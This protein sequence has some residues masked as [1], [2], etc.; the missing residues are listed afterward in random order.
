MEQRALVILFTGNEVQDGTM[1][2]ICQIISQSAFSHPEDVRMYT[3]DEDNLA[4]LLA[5]N[6]MHD[7]SKKPTKVKN[8]ESAVTMLSK[9]F[10]IGNNVALTV[11]L[12]RAIPEIYGR[13]KYGKAIQHD[14]DTVENIK[15]ILKDNT[16]TFNI[17]KSL[18]GN[19]ETIKVIRK[20]FNTYFDEK[21]NV[22]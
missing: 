5:K 13:I 9:E 6:I 8:V 22:R 14:V 16:D 7:H 2:K 15:L 11:H 10:P 21:G 20:I 18:G 3:F 1:A 4:K 19:Q 12:G 17:I